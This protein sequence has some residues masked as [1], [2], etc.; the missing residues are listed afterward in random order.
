M[1]IDNKNTVLTEKVFRVVHI[2]ITVVS[3]GMLVISLIFLAAKWNTLP[4]EIGVH[5]SSTGEFDLY[6]EKIHAFYPYLLGFGCLLFWEVASILAKKLKSG[7]KINVDGER[8]FRA[9]VCIL[10][11]T[12]KICLSVF[13]VNWAD[14]VIRQKTMNVKIPVIASEIVGAAFIL[15]L[16]LMVVIRVKYKKVQE[17]SNE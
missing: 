4:K 12:V 8:L 5:F 7:M 15:F 6:D 11:D 14:C 9:V 16:F 10:L 1:N 3:W 17:V 2:T 13:W